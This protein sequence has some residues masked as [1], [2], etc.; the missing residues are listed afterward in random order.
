MPN[1]LL[2]EFGVRFAKDAA[3]GDAEGVRMLQ[4][5][6]REHNQPEVRDALF[7]V[8]EREE[9]R[10]ILEPLYEV[11][12][13]NLT[14]D[15][16]AWVGGKIMR[17]IAAAKEAAQAELE[18]AASA[19]RT[20]DPKFEA[21][22]EALQQKFNTFAKDNPEMLLTMDNLAKSWSKE[23]PAFENIF[24]EAYGLTGGRPNEPTMLVKPVPVQRKRFIPA[25]AV[26]R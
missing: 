21:A 24:Q 15:Q 25:A 18:S 12:K 6:A 2:A 17:D 13:P 10:D 20:L 26:Q 9:H 16:K 14:M 5:L 22:A 7:K 3:R 11:Y 23:S 4:E 1:N 19:N 8:G